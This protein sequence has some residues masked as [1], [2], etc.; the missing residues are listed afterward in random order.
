MQALG[1][2][3]SQMLTLMA[4]SL[5]ARGRPCPSSPL[6]PVQSHI[7]GNSHV[8]LDLLVSSWHI[9]VKLDVVALAHL[10]VHS[11][12]CEPRR[13]QGTPQRSSWQH[14]H[15]CQS[16]RAS[17]NRVAT[18]DALAFIVNRVAYRGRPSVHRGVASRGRPSVHRGSTRTCVS[19]LRRV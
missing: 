7:L 10:S 4:F 1:P 16:T 8:V 11:G 5:S 15:I 2:M 13:L 12:E 17:V 14:S 18:G 19:P 9:L 6:R 3:K